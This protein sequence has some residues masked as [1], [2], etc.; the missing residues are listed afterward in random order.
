MKTL[1][2]I[3]AF[4]TFIISAPQAATP[5]SLNKVYVTVQSDDLF[6]DPNDCADDGTGASCSLRQAL[7]VVAEGG[8]VIIPSGDYC[9]ENGTLTISKNVSVMALAVSISTHLVIPMMPPNADTGS[10]SRAFTKASCVFLPYAVPH[11]VVCL[12][13]VHAH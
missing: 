10:H 13:I 11:G 4:I 2:L 7:E 5:D 3:F 8:E 9:I 6:T 1:L 12:T